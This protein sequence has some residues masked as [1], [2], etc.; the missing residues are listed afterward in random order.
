LPIRVIPIAVQ[1]EQAHA[2]SSEDDGDGKQK[3][4]DNRLAPMPPGK[5]PEQEVG[6]ED[7]SDYERITRC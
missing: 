4:R 7:E 2:P 3:P 6:T 1:A 5:K